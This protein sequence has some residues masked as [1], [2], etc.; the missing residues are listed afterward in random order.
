MPTLISQAEYARRRGVTREAVRQAI[1][2]GRISLLRGKIDP[3]S[4]DRAWAANTHPPGKGGQNRGKRQP[5]AA[6]PGPK[7]ALEPGVSPENGGATF[8]STR[9]RR[10]QAL[11]EMAELDLARRRGEL[12]PAQEVRAA[13]FKSGRRVRDMV[14]ALPDRLSPRLVGLDQFAINVILTEELH[15]ALKEI[16][17][18]VAV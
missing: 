9:T 6:K 3:K 18:A 7:A 2:T 11:A 8:A 13:A 15:R 10:E 12:V 5:R 14:L 1:K 17:D 16:S 4:A